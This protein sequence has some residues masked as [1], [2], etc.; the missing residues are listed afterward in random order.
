[1]RPN[2]FF[3]QPVVLVLCGA[4]MISFSAVFVKVAD[5]P[6]TVSAFYRVFFGFIF[7]FLATLQ[8]REFRPPS[9]RQ[10]LFLL[11]C[12]LT[13]ALDLFFWHKSI[14]YIGPGLATIIGNFQVF[15]LAAAGFLLFGEKIRARFLLAVPLAFAGLF[16]IIGGSWSNLAS[17]DQLGIFYGLLTALCYGAFLLGLRQVQ[18]NGQQTIFSALMCITLC[19]ALLL[20]AKMAVSGDSFILPSFKAFTALLALGLFSQCVGWVMIAG[21]IH[22]IRASLVG[23]ILL[24]QP[25]LSFLWD[26]LLFDRATNPGNWAGVGLTLLAIYLGTTSGNASRRE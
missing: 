24:L 23:L 13:F 21:A 5:V 10:S 14:F 11:F 6:P 12:G 20:G 17:S 25:A 16:L 15:I 19:S 18:G 3:L 1:M 7:L 4:V 2:T 26:V 22:R 8:R 9:T